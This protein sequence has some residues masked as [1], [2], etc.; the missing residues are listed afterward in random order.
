MSTAELAT[1]DKST[2]DENLLSENRAVSK[3]DDGLV[4]SHAN[5]PNSKEA[6]TTDPIPLPVIVVTD[7]TGMDDLMTSTTTILSSDVEV[8]G[9]VALPEGMKVCDVT[10]FAQE[11]SSSTVNSGSELQGAYMHLPASQLTLSVGDSQRTDEVPE[12]V[13]DSEDHCVKDD[14]LGSNVEVADGDE[15][16]PKHSSARQDALDRMAPVV[17]VDTGHSPVVDMI[18][19]AMDSSE[20]HE[21][22]AQLLDLVS[23]TADSPIAKSKDCAPSGGLLSPLP[24]VVG[25]LL[26][27]DE[28]C[29]AVSPVSHLTTSL[30]TDLTDLTLPTN[31]PNSSEV[32]LHSCLGLTLHADGNLDDSTDDL[33]PPAQADPRPSLDPGPA[34]LADLETD[35][36]TAPV[37]GPAS[38]PDEK[39]TLPRLDL[40]TLLDDC[41]SSDV[42]LLPASANDTALAIAD[43]PS[44]AT[45]SAA[46]MVL[47]LGPVMPG[48][49]QEPSPTAL[50]L[51][52]DANS[53]QTA[54]ASVV[55][56]LDQDLPEDASPEKANSGP[57]PRKDEEPTE[58]TAS[59]GDD[60][61]APPA[62]LDASSE[63]DSMPPVN[64][65]PEP[66]PMDNDD[67][68]EDI[69]D[70]SEDQIDEGPSSPGLPP[71]SPPSSQVSDLFLPPPEESR[72]DEPTSSQDHDYD[73]EPAANGESIEEKGDDDDLPLPSSQPRT[74]SPDRVFSSPPPH[75]FSSPPTSPQLLPDDQ[76]KELAEDATMLDD[77]DAELDMSSPTK[78]RVAEDDLREDMKRMVR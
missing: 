34:L 50:S 5:Y 63:R 17:G 24:S 13:T 6:E 16:L 9:P 42:D 67:A 70:Y 69:A 14:G 64:V 78:K 18:S 57:H 58:D 66:I 48:S 29:P 21:T 59:A 39:Q 62:T 56:T 43:T 10:G 36:K 32:P 73:H 19:L 33:D 37:S 52:V 76:K 20:E 51:E 77:V 35:T 31:E 15:P 11:S 47:D 3:D 30:H 25:H 22:E 60:T 75:D 61:P 27:F 72:E 1:E 4:P 74:S 45:K 71:S 40:D 44:A 68:D 54:K 55:E 26:L 23:T 41:A 7:E 2:P 65:A 28:A 46:A 12:T 53:P 38:T 8:I 49:L